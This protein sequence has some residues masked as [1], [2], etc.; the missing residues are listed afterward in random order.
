MDE[1]L[2]PHLDVLGAWTDALLL[3]L[4]ALGASMGDADTGPA[5]FG[6]SR[7]FLLANAGR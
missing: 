1:V 5:E 7:V 4:L 6:P 3:V 2:P